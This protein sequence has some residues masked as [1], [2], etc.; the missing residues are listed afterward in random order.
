MLS[1]VSQALAC[2]ICAGGLDIGDRVVRCRQGHSFDVA[3]EGYV[4]LTAGGRG[5]ST[6][7]TPAM[8]A[9]RREFLAS[10]HFQPI[11]R[12]IIDTVRDDLD[13]TTSGVFVDAAGG[14]GAYLRSL[15][16]AFP[17]R[18]GVVVDASK[19]AARL[20]ARSHARAA[21]VV[22]DVW[23]T[24]PLKDESAALVT[25]IFGPRN[26][27]QFARVLH[28]AGRLLVVTP[29]D[30]HL[31]ELVVPLGLL[32]VDPLKRE[33]L[34]RKLAPLFVPSCE[35]SVDYAAV[36]TRAQ[37]VCVALMGPSAAHVDRSDIE[38][39]AA[40]LSDLTSVTVSVNVTTFR[41]AADPIST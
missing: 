14:T 20:A 31:Q 12:M 27:E 6:A 24:L 19:H 3:R 2:P 16:D 4:N 34:T 41:R 33:R 26:A 13:E 5:A 7:D 10:G 9:A 15:L 21:A 37:V 29:N 25:S 22:S 1:D 8:V 39:R 40:G 23:G 32:E 36:L 17:Q 28:P 11:T 38:S 30:S 35:R 18:A